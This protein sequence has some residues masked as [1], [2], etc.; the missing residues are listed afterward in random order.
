MMPEQLYLAAHV[1]DRQLV[2]RGGR[3]CGK[4][5]DLELTVDDATGEL[6]VTAVLC[7][8]G[9]LLGRLGRRRSSTWLRRLVTLLESEDRG[10]VPIRDVTDFGNHVSLS[11]DASEL[12]TELTERW[13]RDHVIS[14]IPGSRFRAGQ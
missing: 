12:A 7:G 6:F 5:D 2:D 1:L 4:V 3:H 10:R 13:V 8:P 9:A 11:V 14:H